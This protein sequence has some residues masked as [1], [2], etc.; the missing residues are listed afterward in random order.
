MNKFRY[1]LKSLWFYKKQHFAVLFAT[2]VSTA[3]LTGALIIGDSVKY[4]LRELVNLRLG[5][6]EYAMQLGDRYVRTDLAKEMAEDLNAV[7]SPVLKLSGLSINP[8]SNIRVND[9]QVYGIDNQFWNL[10][11]TIAQNLKD[12]EVIV[13]HNLAE[14]MKL[15]PGDQF[16]LRVEKG[17]LIPANA[18]FVSDQD[19][20]LALRLKVKAIADKKLLG[21]FSLKSN[22][23]APFNVFLSRKYL[24]EEMELKTFSNLILIASKKGHLITKE[25]INSSLN[26]NWKIE[27]ASLEIREIKE[28]SRFELISKRVFIDRVISEQISQIPLNQE[29]LLTYFVNGIKSDNAETPY[30]FVSSLSGNNK[31]QLKDNEIVINEWLAKDLNLS[32]TDSIQLRYFVIG[33]LRHLQEKNRSFKVV[34]IVPNYVFNK[35]MMPN[36]PGLSG[37]GSCNEWEAGVP[38][39]FSKIRKKDEDYWEKYKGSPKA[40]IS[41]KNATNL[42]SNKYGDCTAIRFDNSAS[43]LVDLKHKLLKVIRPEMLNIQFQ[44]V[45]DEGKKAANNMV[46]FGSLFLSLSFFILVAAVLLIVLI[47]SLNIDNRNKETGILLSLG[48]KPKAILEIRVYESFVSIFFGGVLGILG[49]IIYN[50]LLL[51]ALNSVWKDVVRTNMLSVNLQAY[52]LLLGFVLG[53]VIAMICIFIVS[54]KKLRQSALSL[55]RN[56]N[57]EK[58]STPRCSVYLLLALFLFLVSLL[59]VLY[60]FLSSLEQNA[61]LLLSA[62][63]IFLMA[64]SAFVYYYFNAL[65]GKKSSVT[66]N[67]WQLASKNAVRNTKRSLAIVILLALG[68]FSVLITGANRKT[69]FNVA[70]VNSSGTGGYDYWI[71]SSLPVLTDLNSKEGQ[72]KAGFFDGDLNDSVEFVQFKTLEGDDASCLNLNQ[73]SKP[74]ILGFKTSYFEQRKAFSFVK[75]HDS[76]DKKNPWHTLNQSIGEEVIPAFADQTVI[77]WGLKKSVGDTLVYQNEFGKDIKLLLLGGLANSIFQGNILIA[78]HQFQKHFPSVSGSKVILADCNVSDTLF[79]NKLEDNFQDLGF[80]GVKTSDRLAA[81]Y[82]V[83]NTYLSMFMFLGGLGIVIGTIGLGIVLLRNIWERKK[84]LALL[85][86]IGYTAKDI[87]KLLFYENFFLLICGLFCGIGAALLAVLPSLFSPAFAIPYLYVGLLLGAMLLSGVLWILIPIINFRKNN[88]IELLKNE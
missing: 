11:D 19:Q 2:V 81:F 20:S 4:S 60:V 86:A 85:T 78:E 55:I 74:R 28:T 23:V 1:I 73:V 66:F 3:V 49:G 39:D 32:I 48:L 22:Q 29:T 63:G 9:V 88:I 5:K 43:N 51:S 7:V 53:I 75:L 8:E 38:L 71:D 33:D 58:V 24:A 13:S 62:G 83:E 76:V 65:A 35:S 26:R 61:E 30:S 16:L 70:N 80:R 41:K 47:Y 17:S 21:Q 18:P 50:K 25:D 67:L 15:L 10:T 54:R 44:S 87:F 14:R 45:R 84:E 37:A 56:V 34:R 40:I 27:D 52:S 64:E 36:F 79:M 31:Y 82:S 57:Q 68:T 46:D 59:L 42:W 69:F 77:V 72:V 6:V 12:D